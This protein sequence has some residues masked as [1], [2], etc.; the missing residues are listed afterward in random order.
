MASS[1]RSFDRVV[2]ISYAG[3]QFGSFLS[4][5]CSD[6]F[7]RRTTLMLIMLP[8]LGLFIMLGMAQSFWVVCVAIFL[9]NFMFGLKNAASAIYVSEIR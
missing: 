6:A 7:G 2:S 1:S 9:L 3:V 4:G 5:F 8:V